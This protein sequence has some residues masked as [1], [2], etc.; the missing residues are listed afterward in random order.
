VQVSTFANYEYAMYWHLYQDGSMQ[1]EMKL[2]GILSTS[3]QYT[4][5]GKP[6]QGVLV[7]PGVAASN[8]QHFFCFRIDPAVDD[9][10]GGRNL[11][12]SEVGVAGAC[13]GRRGPGRARGP[14]AGAA[15]ATAAAAEALEE[16]YPLAAAG[17]W[18]GP[19]GPRSL[20]RRPAHVGGVALSVPP[21][22]KECVVPWPRP[23]RAR[24]HSALRRRD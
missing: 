10:D 13:G 15:A 12:V 17:R 7:A 3:V 22:S 1:L 16:H 20:P 6:Q 18:A 11:V 14:S 21:R 24:S 8:H 9:A 19:C 23:S 5:E 2:T 4:G